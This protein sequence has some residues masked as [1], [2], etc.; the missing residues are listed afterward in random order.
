MGA[1]GRANFE[2]RTRGDLR[3]AAQFLFDH[4]RPDPCLDKEE[5]Q[6]DRRRGE[7][8]RRI[9]ACPPGSDHQRHQAQARRERPGPV[10]E[11]HEDGTRQGGDPLA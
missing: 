6:R 1:T 3:A 7:Q 4:G 10:S 2:G 11:L 8:G 9:P 5:H